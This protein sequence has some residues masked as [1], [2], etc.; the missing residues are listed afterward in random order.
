MAPRKIPKHLS[1][2]ATNAH[3][4]HL[5]EKL[6]VNTGIVHGLREGMIEMPAVGIPKISLNAADN[7]CIAKK[8]AMRVQ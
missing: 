8:A 2:N 6:F 7:D 1:K 4:R 5:P 3:V